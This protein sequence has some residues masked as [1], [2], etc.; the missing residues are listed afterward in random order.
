MKRW[1]YVLVTGF[2]FLGSTALAKDLTEPTVVTLLN[3]ELGW[4][5]EVVLPSLDRVDLIG[6]GTAWEA[7]WLEKHEE[8]IS[9]A[10]RYSTLTG[11][12]PGL[13]IFVNDEIDRVEY[14][15]MMLT[16]ERLKRHGLEIRL[17]MY[18]VRKREWYVSF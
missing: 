14:L 13:I 6:D 18:N 11:L 3:A 1:F 12:K 2:L 17:K 5:E 8:G 16:L 7:D 15:R 10:I 9:Q 4:Q